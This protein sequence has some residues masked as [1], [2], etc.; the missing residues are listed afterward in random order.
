MAG[1]TLKYIREMVRQSLMED[2]NFLKRYLY[3][4]EMWVPTDVATWGGYFGFLFPLILPPTA[5]S[6]EEP[7]TVEVT[8]TQGGG[9]YVEENGIVQRTIRISGHTGFK[10]RPLKLRLGDAYPATVPMTKRSHGREL[11]RTILDKISGQRHFQYLQDSV[12]RTYGDLKRDPTTAKDTKLMFHNPKDQEHWIVVPQRFTLDRDASSPLLY[13]YNIELLVVGDAGEV[14][15]DFSEDKGIMD[16]IKDFMRTV[17]NAIDMVT[18]AFNDL[19]AMVNEIKIFIN[20]IATILDAVSGILLAAGDFVDG[21]TELVET[22]FESIQSSWKGLED[23]LQNLQ[24]RVNPDDPATPPAG[25]PDATINRLRTMQAGLELMGM[26][27]A[28]YISSAEVTMK[29]IREEQEPGR[30]FGEARLTEALGSEPPT[31]FDEVNARGTRLTPGDALSARG[32]VTT[33]SA[34]KKY[35]SVRQVTVEQGDTL[36]GLAARYMGDARA[37]QYIAI[38]NGLKPPFIDSQASIPLVAGVGTG[39]TVSGIASGADESP[40]GNTLGIG[41]KILIPSN[42]KST[43]DLP[44]LPVAGARVEES[45]EDQFLGTDLKL[46]AV[47]GIEGSGH[48]MYDIPIDTDLGGMDAMTVSGMNNLKQAVITRLVTEKGT[49]TLYRAVG[50]QRVVGLGF[51]PLDLE[52]AKFRARESIGSDPRIAAVRNLML[53]QDGDALEIDMRAEVRGFAESRPVRATV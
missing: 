46:E 43:I 47:S 8:P 30:K 9:L 4:F 1:S 35:K 42:L 20:G 44:I 5:Y 45:A 50:M 53:K 51:S 26:Y 22:P 32:A 17:K 38:A 34:L 18:G 13:R 7:F 41:S 23:A 39:S 6:M 28:I 24:D 29:Q 14:R 3:F 27:P 21:V 10:P 36:M 12:F 31:S 16:S 19:T 15:A 40:F 11:P 52:M 33:G 37:W 2:S 25:L 48:A 49:D